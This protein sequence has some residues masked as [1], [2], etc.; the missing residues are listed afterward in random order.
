MIPVL[1]VIAWNLA[2]CGVLL[3]HVRVPSF[4]YSVRA[5][6]LIA[7]PRA[8]TPDWVGLV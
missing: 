5:P 4:S 3:R 2:V 6:K 8:S 7:V 1:G